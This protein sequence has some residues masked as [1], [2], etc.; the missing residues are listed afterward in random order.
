MAFMN[1]KWI[2]AWK[3]DFLYSNEATN[4]VGD[5]YS[6]AFLSIFTSIRIE[7][8]WNDCKATERYVLIQIPVWMQCY[9]DVCQNCMG[10]AAALARRAQAHTYT[11]EHRDIFQLENCQHINALFVM[12]G[13]IY[14]MIWKLFQFFHW[15]W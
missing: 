2:F 6:I 8:M 3:I 9:S 1:S 10:I 7:K 12:A 15:H 5:S 14:N 13:Y 11:H 4:F